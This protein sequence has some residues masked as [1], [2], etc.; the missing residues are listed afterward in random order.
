MCLNNIILNCWEI[1]KIV[2]LQHRFEIKS[3]VT[4]AKAEKIN[5]MIARLNP[6]Q[7]LSIDNQQLSFE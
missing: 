3:S 5:Y 2:K 7:S 1:L 6:K 4:V